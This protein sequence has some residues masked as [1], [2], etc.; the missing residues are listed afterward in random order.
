MTNIQRKV[1]YG[2]RVSKIR[3]VRQEGRRVE[4][5]RATTRTAA[6]SGTQ[7]GSLRRGEKRRMRQMAVSA[8]ILAL[9]V[10]VKL[11]FPDVMDSYRQQ[12]LKLLGE[13][14]DFVAA[15]SS[16]GRAFSSEGSVGQALNDAYT[17][18]FGAQSVTQEDPPAANPDHSEQQNDPDPADSGDPIPK[19][20]DGQVIYSD[21]N[22]PENVCMTQ[23]V[24]GFSYAP[25]VDGTV[26][27]SFGYRIHPILEDE[28][29]HY[30]VDVGADSGTIVRAFAA[31]TVTV[32][33]EASELGNYVIVSH[34]GGFSTLYAHCSIVTASPGQ[35]VASGDPIAEVGDTGMT[36][37][38]HLHFELMH[39][40]TYLDP[41][42]YA[43]G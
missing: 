37:G 20:E 40:S 10:A 43:L 36:T 19:T 25:P 14:T 24:L 15:F 26:T 7:D 16:V 23:Q 4:A 12:V 28:R 3:P 9:V 34:S 2:R 32:V 13:N 22:T 30:G 35:Q 6:G 33:A 18:V 42:Y 8:V 5:G 31:G 11:A 27:S 21:A 1:Q 39:G 41:M 17:A 38:P 29:F